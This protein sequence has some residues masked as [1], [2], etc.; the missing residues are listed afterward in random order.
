MLRL[1]RGIAWQHATRQSVHRVRTS[2]RRPWSERA[3]LA[4]GCRVQDFLRGPGLRASGIWVGAWGVE[5]LGFC[6][7]ARV[8]IL[9]VLLFVFP[10]AGLFEH[11]T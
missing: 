2:Q 11:P 10:P 8:Y 1:V 6:A 5:G 3:T 7:D 9:Y 4:S